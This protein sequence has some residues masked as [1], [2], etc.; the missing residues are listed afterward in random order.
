M[1]T[2]PG[3]PGVAVRSRDREA[4][5]EARLVLDAA[6]IESELLY[7]DGWWLLLVDTSD[8]PRAAEEHEA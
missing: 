3:D 5:L 8:L 2:N 1:D 7:L 4:S 6:G